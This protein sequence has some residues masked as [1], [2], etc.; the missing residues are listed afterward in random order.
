LFAPKHLKT[1][2]WF[3]GA[4]GL[5]AILAVTAQ[6]SAS[7]FTDIPT[8][9]A[10]AMDTTP[11]V[12]EFLLGSAILLSVI[13]GLGIAQVPWMP[14]LMISLVMIGLVTAIGWFDVWILAFA[15]MLTAALFGAAAKGWIGG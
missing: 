4:F 1:I 11:Y 10:N 8:R 13:L 12:A 7:P 5:L 6:A 2:G 14:T 15:A 9:L 3:A